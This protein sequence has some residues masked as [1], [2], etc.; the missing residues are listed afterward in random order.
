VQPRNEKYFDLL[1][2]TELM[3]KGT[4]KRA[5]NSVLADIVM[6]IWLNGGIAGRSFITQQWRLIIP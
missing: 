4:K 1:L 5:P 6:Q 3:K 2:F